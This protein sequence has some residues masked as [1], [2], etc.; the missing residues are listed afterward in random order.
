MRKRLV[1]ACLGFAVGVA[2]LHAQVTATNAPAKAFITFAY[3]V[4]D[5]LIEGTPDW[6][7]DDRWD[8]STKAERNF[9]PT[10]ID[11]SRRSTVNGCSTDRRSVWT[12]R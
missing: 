8:V 5:F 1:V 4:Q 3:R 9:P 6:V 10:T 11:G 7:K 2:T 12:S